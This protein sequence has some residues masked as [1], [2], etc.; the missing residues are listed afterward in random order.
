MHLEQWLKNSPVLT[1]GAWG[2]ELQQ[3]G[4]PAGEC[5][6]HWNLAFPEKVMKVAR[7]YVEAGSQIIL[8]NTFRSNRVTLTGHGLADQTRTLNRKGVTLSRE[9]ASGRAAVFA[10]M[11]PTGKM[12]MMGETSEDEIKAAFTEQAEALAEA[13]ADALIL[14]TMTDLAEAKIALAAARRVGLPVIVSFVFDSGKQ[15]DRT[16][17]GATPEQV[18]REITEAGADGLGA[19]CGLGISGFIPLCRRLK[20]ATSLPVWIKANA[21]LPEIVDGKPVYRTS[22]E[23]F[24]SF[25]PSLADAGADFV[26]GCCGTNPAFIAACAQVMKADRQAT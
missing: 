19:N 7:S 4:L 9:A 12:L 20:A 14:E 21:G 25:V 8:T 16:M 23:D 10:S 13:G 22:P 5:P 2:T 11:G 15:K 18:A 24:A 3:Q 17:M 6:D 26:G 1:D